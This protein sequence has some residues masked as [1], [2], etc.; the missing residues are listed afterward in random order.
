MLSESFYCR[1]FCRLS[2][3]T[4]DDKLSIGNLYLYACSIDP[5]GVEEGGTAVHHVAYV[6]FHLSVVYLL[7]VDDECYLLGEVYHVIGEIEGEV[8]FGGRN[9]LLV[10]LGGDVPDGFALG[11]L[12]GYAI[13]GEADGVAFDA[14]LVAGAFV[15]AGGVALM[16]GNVVEAAAVDAVQGE[17]FP[18]EVAGMDDAGEVAEP[19]CSVRVVDAVT[20]SG[21]EFYVVAVLGR[22]AAVE[23]VE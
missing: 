6:G 5:F 23:A 12:I 22:V 14:H 8:A 9:I 15:A 3:K 7:T 17:V 13:Y 19:R 21:D 1:V 10:L 4:I 11:G 16:Y 18:N 2:P 20:A